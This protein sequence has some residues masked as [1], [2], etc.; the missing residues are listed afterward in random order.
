MLDIVFSYM[1]GILISLLIFE[2]FT[3]ICRIVYGLSVN[4]LPVCG[5]YFYIY[6]TDL[7]CFSFMI[8][9]FCPVLKYL[10]LLNYKNGP[11]LSYNF[12]GLNFKEVFDPSDIEFYIQ[13][14]VGILFFHVDNILTA[15]FIE[16]FFLS[17]TICKASS[18]T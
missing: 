2:L 7:S 18:V 16:P 1:W 10:Y 8:S 17:L 15:W 5:L 9:A 14:E 12:K 6:V 3:L 13:C 4:P 11:F